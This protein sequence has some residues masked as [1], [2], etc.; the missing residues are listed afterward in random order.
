LIFRCHF[1]VGCLLPSL[2]FLS[3]LL[4][5]AAGLHLLLRI[6]LVLL[7]LLIFL[8]LMC[9]SLSCV[10]TS[11]DGLLTPLP[12]ADHCETTQEMWT[13]PDELWLLMLLLCV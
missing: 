11:L 13:R 7:L 2:L 8:L 9:W 4:A 12:S 3:G 10:S 1:I 6:L 5:L